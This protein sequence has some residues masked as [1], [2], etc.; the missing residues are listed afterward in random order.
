MGKDG[1]MMRLIGLIAV[2]VISLTAIH[3]SAAHPT[4][5]TLGKKS[6]LSEEIYSQKNE[7]RL[8]RQ[9]VELLKTKINA[10]GNIPIISNAIKEYCENETISHIREYS[11]AQQIYS[12][13]LSV[14]ASDF[15]KLYSTMHEGEPW[16]LISKR[17]AEA[18]AVRGADFTPFDGYAFIDDP[19]IND[20]SVDYGLFAI[21]TNTI[22]E[23]DGIRLFWIGSKGEVYWQSV[24]DLKKYG[25]IKKL[26]DISSPKISPT[27]WNL[28]EIQYPIRVEENKR[29]AKSALE[30]YAYSQA[31]YGK[32][33][34]Q[35][36]GSS[37]QYAKDY[38]M[39]YSEEFR[40][41][42]LRLIS[43]TFADARIP[44][45]NG[46]F[47]GYVF[48]D[49]P[50]VKDWNN[51]FGLIAIPLSEEYGSHLFWIGTEGIVYEQ[52]IAKGQ[53]NTR[54]MPADIKSPIVNHLLWKVAEE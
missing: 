50:S 26:K 17:F 4:E 1:A 20:W 22:A 29:N 47:Y 24:E 51:N 30:T 3:P 12:K 34:K 45:G 28:V 32:I 23:I 41:T 36:P 27:R 10:I 37:A 54:F 2:C 18:G 6:S 11:A 35:I 8:L 44:G 5:S 48:Y 40:G 33:I 31:M 53:L 19:N 52:P 16:R 43:K 49:D 39:L 25:G 9:E 7:I 14:Y 42:A 21:P 13:V 46:S 38:S 15:A